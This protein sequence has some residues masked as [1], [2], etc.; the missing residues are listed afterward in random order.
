MASALLLTH[1]RHSNVYSAGLADMMKRG[2]KMAKASTEAPQEVRVLKR[3]SMSLNQEYA[4]GASGVVTV[5]V[6]KLS[7]EQRSELRKKLKRGLE[8]VRL[9]VSRID[10]WLEVLSRGKGK[11]LSQSQ[12]QLQGV[13]SEGKQQQQQQQHQQQC[14]SSEAK[15]GRAD[16]NGLGQGPGH[17]QGQGRKEVASVIS[18]PASSSGET[19]RDMPKEMSEREARLARQPSVL[20]PEV[21]LGTP[22][23]KMKRTPK[24][25]QLYV[26]SEFVSGKDKM[27]A[28]EKAKAKRTASGKWETKDPRRQ[29]VEAARGKRVADMLKQCTT[30]LRKLMTHKHGW[31]FNEPVDAE[32]LGLH[33]Y[34]SIIKKPMDL[35]TIKKKLH[36]KGYPSPVEFAE[37]IRLTFANAMTYNPVGHDVYVMAELLKSIF[38]EWWKN[39]SRK[40]EEEKRRAEKEE[41]MLLNDEDSVEETGEVRRGERDL[42]S[43][44]R[45]KTS[46]RMASQPKPR[47]DEV[48]KRAMTFEEKRKLS[49]N[50]ERL[51]GDKLERIVQII[52]KRNPDLGQNEDEI[53]VD[54]DSF[55]NDTL[56]ELDRFVTNYMKSRG[57]KA[58][59]KAARGGGGEV[60]RGGRAGGEGGEKDVDIDDDVGPAKFAPVV[61]D[62]GRESSSS[63]S[64]S[65]DSGSSD[66]DSDSGSSSGSESDAEDGQTGG[67]GPKASHDKS[68]ADFPPQ[69]MQDPVGREPASEQKDS[70]CAEAEAT[71]KD[72]LVVHGETVSERAVVPEKSPPARQVSPEKQLR[73]ALLKG[74]FADLIVKSQGK[75]LPDSKNDK[76]DPEKL[77]RDR[78]EMERRQREEKARLH[79]EAKAAEITKRKAEAE[80]ALLEKQKREVEREEA[81]RELQQMERTVEIDE[82]SGILKDLERLRS[83]PLE[84]MLG[85]VHDAGNGEEGSPDG[86]STIALQGGSNPLEQLGLFMRND[87]EEEDEDADVDGEDE[88]EVECGEAREEGGEEDEVVDVED[89]EIDVD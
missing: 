1:E 20:I 66:S 75:A 79:A 18:D 14:R 16:V 51:P 36:G 89:G 50:L 38:E 22:S 39:M 64:D 77:K 45:G 25:N 76:V 84:A 69:A 74:R 56:W 9:V 57:K 83:G 65:S 28:P 68:I 73:A 26:N 10:T 3:K 12:S 47:P 21:A 23:E 7:R 86:S 44:T 6:A 52:K 62:K 24:A 70:R 32:K 40:M 33:D 71:K 49:V 8:E 54:I 4:Q 46:S 2:A 30:L 37:D 81:R 67:A 35:G 41:E 53:E 88:M 34:H 27:P 85:S 5:D 61:I 82:N 13:A 58:K 63:G 60:R 31:V 55:D 43:L 48:G 19:P 17:G 15:L 29:K 11:P 42:S 87:D 59:S 72:V 78:E 80:A